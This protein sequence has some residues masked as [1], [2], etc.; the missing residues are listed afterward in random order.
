ME[1]IDILN[2]AR[3]LEVD[4]HDFYLKT[5][6]AASNELARKTFESF[7]KDEENHI[8][9]IDDAL[10]GEGKAAVNENAAEEV[11]STL[12][13]IFKDAPEDLKGN[14][15]TSS[16]ELAA[17]EIAVGKEEGSI[18]AYQEWADASEDADIK[19]LF[20]T[21]VAV[22]KTHRDLLN[23]TRTY[24]ESTGDWFMVDEQWSFDGA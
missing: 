9:W 19:A 12:K 2:A 22:E 11:Y 14:A 20:T 10:K 21:L 1:R 5:A 3:N 8:K 15:G 23:N 18:K 13:G 17:I 4:G 16:D 7:A 24:L 6:A